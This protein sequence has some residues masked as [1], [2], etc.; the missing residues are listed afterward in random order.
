MSATAEF[1]VPQKVQDLAQF[2]LTKYDMDYEIVKIPDAITLEGQPVKSTYHNLVNT[3][4]MEKINAVKV[5]YTIS[6][7]REV[8]EMVL[9]GMEQ[10]AGL[11]VE[12]FDDLHGG[13]KT[14]IQLKIQGDALIPRPDGS[15]DTITRYVTILDS[16]DGTSSLSIGIG[17]KTASCANQFFQFY[18][19]GEMRFRHSASIQEKIKALPTYIEL[20][21]SESM[22]MVNL[23][24]EFES[25]KITRSLAQD[26]LVTEILGHN[27]HDDIKGKAKSNMDTLYRELNKEMND[28]GDNLWGLHSG[29]TRWTT[30]S[31][32]APK[33]R[34]G[35]I[36]SSMTSTNYKVNQKSL[37]FA[38][39]L[40]ADLGE[41][42]V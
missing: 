29:V 15:M 7:T 39:K 16:N 20:A 22:R 24:K 13:R 3:K 27:K 17:D 40:L 37:A 8:L 33:R 4:T 1:K 38:E 34:N 30:H 18:K 23:Y 36:E 41:F 10:F 6:Q 12:R 9:M 5:S 25:T 14:F 31:K 32:Q 21:L 26:A 42:A 11:E 28:K 2:Y 19:A 35:R